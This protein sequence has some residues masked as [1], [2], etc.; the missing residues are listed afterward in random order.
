[1][2]KNRGY[3]QLV[4]NLVNIMTMASN[5][6]ELS[7]RAEQGG[8]MIWYYNTQNNSTDKENILAIYVTNFLFIRNCEQFS[9]NM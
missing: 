5:N 2:H 6:P 4:P 1:M 9:K 3:I 7:T 8:A